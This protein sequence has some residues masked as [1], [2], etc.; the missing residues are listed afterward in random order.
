MSFF[1]PALYH[2][3][4]PRIE[5]DKS[6]IKTNDIEFFVLRITLVNNSMPESLESLF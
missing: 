1:L 2:K 5:S 6:V 3:A 4:N